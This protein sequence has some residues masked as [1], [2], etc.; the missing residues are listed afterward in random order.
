GLGVPL[1]DLLDCPLMKRLDRLTLHKHFHVVGD[2]DWTDRV[3]PTLANEAVRAVVTCPRLAGLTGL[4]LGDYW[5]MTP[6][7]LGYLAE[8]APE[9]LRRLDLSIE[10]VPRSA[11]LAEAIEGRDEGIARLAV[12]PRL[13]GLTELVLHDN[14]LTDAALQALAQSPLL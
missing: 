3:D 6:S 2:D 11:D 10:D 12:A 1:A 4:G 5:Y 14:A 13:A 8:F 7:G 9:G